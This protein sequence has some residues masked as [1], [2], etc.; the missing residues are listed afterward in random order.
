MFNRARGGAIFST[1]SP[2]PP[3]AVVP[4][5]DDHDDDDQKV[6]H[7]PKFAQVNFF[8]F[9]IFFIG[10]LLVILTLLYCRSGQYVLF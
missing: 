4:I 5:N 10:N 1:L 6:A 9:I 7:L 3:A 2:R 8:I